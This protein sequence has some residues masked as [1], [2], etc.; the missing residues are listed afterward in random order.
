MKESSHSSVNFVIIKQQESVHEGVKPFKCIICTFETGNK[1]NLKIHI[2]SVHEGIKPF[3][4]S[5]CNFNKLMKE[6]SLSNVK[7]KH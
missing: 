4:C 6:G 2:D 7:F 1:T 5:I 3:K